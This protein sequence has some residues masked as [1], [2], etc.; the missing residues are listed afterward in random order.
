MYVCMYVQDLMFMYVCMYVC[1]IIWCDWKWN[2][3]HSVCAA[4]INFE[5]L[6]SLL[7]SGNTISIAIYIVSVC[8]FLYFSALAFNCAN[9]VYVFVYTVR[10]YVCMYVICMYVCATLWI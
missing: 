5:G 3:S 9:C 6:D 2:G 10:M 8:I 1:G 7:R 4:W